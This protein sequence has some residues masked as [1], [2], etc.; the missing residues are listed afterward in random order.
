MISS[1]ESCA[2]AAALVRLSRTI[3]NKH[4][5]EF[6]KADRQIIHKEFVYTGKSGWDTALPTLSAK[7]VLFCS[8]DTVCSTGNG[9]TLRDNTQFYTCKVLQ[10]G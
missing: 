3:A 8:W 1:D 6:L 4:L 2:I 5:D 10:H 9:P 7:D